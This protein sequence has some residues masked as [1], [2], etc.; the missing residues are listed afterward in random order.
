M[1]S[2]NYNEHLMIA[3]HK[4]RSHQKKDELKM[5]ALVICM[6]DDDNNLC[7]LGFV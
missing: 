5:C 1:V 4:L 6:K 2:F 3:I 7:S